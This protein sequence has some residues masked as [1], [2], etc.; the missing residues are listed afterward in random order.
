[1]VLAGHVVFALLTIGVFGFF[2]YRIRTSW[3]HFRRL[4]QGKEDV[5]A[6]HKA[7]R[8]GTM[9][10]RGLLQGKMFKD[11]VPGVMHFLIFWGFVTVTVGT[12]EM[13]LFGMTGSFSYTSIIGGGGLFHF[14][15][16]SQDWANFIVVLAAVFAILRRLFFPPARLKSLD[17]HARADALVVLG[18]I[19][20]LVFTELVVKGS[21]ARMGLDPH[22]PAADLFF[23][24]HIAGLF[25][26]NSEG[27]LRTLATAFWAA[28]VTVLFSFIV[29]LP[30]SKHQHLIWVWPNIFFKSH[31][32]I[33]RLRPM[34]FDEDAESFGVGRV[35]GFTWKQ[36]LDGHTCVECGRCTEQCP[37]SQTGKKLD[38]RR[39]VHHLKEAVHDALAAP[40]EGSRKSLIGD[41]VSVDELWACTTCG[42]CMEACPLE[43]EHIPAIVDMRR[44]LVMTESRIPS[45]GE[46]ALRNLENAA[47]PWGLDNSTRMD[48]ASGLDVPT[49]AEK[50]DV[51]YLFWVGCAGA[52]DERKK[53]VTRS[54]ARILQHAGV[55][56]AVLGN[57]ERCNGD[58]ARRLGNEYLATMLIEE[59]V[60]T[61]KNYGV[62]KVITTCPHCFNTL[63]NEYPDFGLEMEVVHHSEFIADLLKSGRVKLD[64]AA[65]AGTVTY[66]DS[67][68]LGRHNQVYDAP[69]D[70]LNLVGASSVE[71]PRSRE[72][73]F[74]CGA[75][76]GRMWMEETEGTR[77]NVDRTREALATG[78]ATVATACPFCMTM[79]EDGV[80]EEGKQESVAVR[81]LAEVV[82]DRLPR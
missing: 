15:L 61:L 14:Y 80:K 81:D 3:T 75:G 74:C 54:V 82:A 22:L 77:V 69:R 37:A 48:W 78:A 43:I 56:F 39:I 29:F 66:H 44:Y 60:Q 12:V 57:E 20:A 6:D 38:P 59:N 34:E 64:G 51:E 25:G 46:R 27:G 68:Y 79:L 28:H 5:R 71:M 52:F 24:T 21:R 40:D 63:R 23:S 11:P 55:S 7:S 32:P 41:I 73:G 17:R 31:R 65:A 2:F 49:M 62:R 45:E 19:L 10:F 30:Y 9:G 50:R 36:L 47:N 35:E 18:L 16:R 70:I 26:A 33:G 58:T 8:L 67:C 72:K 13:L 42:A 53:Q 4:G 1:V 76:G